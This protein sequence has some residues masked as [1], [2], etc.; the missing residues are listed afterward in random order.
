MKSLNF[1]IPLAAA[2]ELHFLLI[3]ANLDCGSSLTSLKC[4]LTAEEQ[5]DEDNDD[6]YDDA[7]DDEDD[8]DA[9]DNFFD[10]C[11]FG[12]LAGVNTEVFSVVGLSLFFKAGT[13]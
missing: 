4:L 5:G 2:P 9:A 11:D 13:F 12:F 6:A 10:V 8:D 3:S 1:A 7:D